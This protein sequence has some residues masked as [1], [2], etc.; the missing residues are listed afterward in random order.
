M[1]FSD[2]L[3]MK[4]PSSLPSLDSLNFTSKDPHMGLNPSFLRF[5][6]NMSRDSSLD[7]LYRASVILLQLVKLEGGTHQSWWGIFR[8]FFHLVIFI[9]WQLSPL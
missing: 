9:I 4:R 6:N 7:E 5:V 8:G 2:S 3:N 1:T